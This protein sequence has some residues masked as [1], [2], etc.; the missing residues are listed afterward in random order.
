MSSAA[1]IR[2]IHTLKSRT[3]LDDGDY[4]AL[5]SRFGKASS[6]D[7]SEREA[8]R[9][10]EDMRRLPGAAA[11]APN[12]ARPAA[13]T[14]SGPYAPVLRALWIAAWNLALVRSP[15]DRA[16]MRFVERQTGLSHTRFL[17]D[18]CAASRAIE[19]LK[20]WLARD[21]GVDWPPDDADRKR[22]VCR[23][24]AARLQAA[25]GFTPFVAGADV[26]TSDI[27]RYGYGRGLPAGFGDY[28]ARH[29]DAL[30][31][32]LGA[33]LRGTLARKAREESDA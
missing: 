26:W 11:Q 4:R 14:A 24:I 8:I 3:G 20:A 15:D 9:L 30:A 16:M 23:A 17:V 28:D 5:L 29:W 25:G 7:L 32:W 31:N 21:G 22:A 10:I 1:Q 2:A 6:K 27:E 33:R 13:A 12:G 19:A 18:G